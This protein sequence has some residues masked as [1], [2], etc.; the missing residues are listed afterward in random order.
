ME[1]HTV[2]ACLTPSPTAGGT[3]EPKVLFFF[4]FFFFKGNVRGPHQSCP[5]RVFSRPGGSGALVKG[6]KQFS[7]IE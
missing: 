7:E 1:N 2:V 6:L 3:V 5:V 4:F